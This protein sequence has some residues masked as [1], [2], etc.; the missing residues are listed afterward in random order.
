MTFSVTSRG[1]VPLL[2]ERRSQVSKH[3]HRH[4]TENTAHAERDRT[5][6][7]SAV[8][9][10]PHGQWASSHNQSKVKIC[11]LSQHAVSKGFHSLPA[12]DTYSAD[13]VPCD[14]HATAEQR[15]IHW[16][17]V[18]YSK[19]RLGDQHKQWGL[20]V[21][22][23]KPYRLEPHSSVAEQE[24]EDCIPEA[25]SLFLSWSKDFFSNI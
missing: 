17:S 13:R 2:Q 6:S 23:R 8:G 12:R 20:C 1:R 18:R 10:G 3:L 14:S 7:V 15:R 11:M 21:Y 16:S 19:P 22:V 5:R 9:V 25:I 24:L 4:R